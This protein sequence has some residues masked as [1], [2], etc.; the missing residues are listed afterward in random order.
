MS[1]W[2]FWSVS[3]GFINK[4]RLQTTQ[5][6]NL[7]EVF[8]W[9]KGK[10]AT[11]CNIRNFRLFF[12]FF[13]LIFF[14]NLGMSSDVPAF[15]VRAFTSN[16]EFWIGVKWI[17]VVDIPT[18]NLLTILLS[19]DYSWR[20]KLKVYI[21]THIKEKSSMTHWYFFAKS[22]K[23]MKVK[24]VSKIWVRMSTTNI[25][26]L[27]CKIQ[28]TCKNADFECWYIKTHNKEKPSKMVHFNI[29]TRKIWS[30]IIS[31]V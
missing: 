28:V 25:H 26:L 2:P 7:V 19:I 14:L 1:E 10:P 27:Q 4:C 30:W 13:F 31:S 9:E 6:D 11:K 21:I 29:K 3:N 20:C 24:R 23:A 12:F 16:F 18:K 5:D 22:V 8:L 15:K 17:L